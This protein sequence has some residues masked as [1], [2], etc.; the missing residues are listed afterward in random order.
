V[1]AFLLVLFDVNIP[2]GGEKFIGLL[3]A[4]YSAQFSF[5]PLVLG[6][7]FAKTHPSPPWA[8][9]SLIS[10]GLSGIALGVY[11]VFWNDSVGWYPIL[12]CFSLSTAVYLLGEAVKKNV[13]E[14][15]YKFCL[16]N[17]VSLSVLLGAVG[18]SI[19]CPWPMSWPGWFRWEVA[20]FISTVL[21]SFYVY[22][23]KGTLFSPQFMLSNNRK[24]KIGLVVLCIIILSIAALLSVN[25]RLHW[26]NVPD[27]DRPIEVKMGCLWISSILF[28]I[29]VT[30]LSKGGRNDRVAK[31]FRQSLRYSDGPICVSFGLLFFYACWLGEPRIKHEGMESF[32]AGAIAFQMILSNIMWMFA[33]NALVTPAD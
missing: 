16:A 3:I 10:G 30:L 11:S 25:G 21:Y 4:I 20:A 24:H 13:V 33:D 29:A 8:A 2:H 22:I 28:V 15:V 19:F 18:Y 26:V 31:S 6:I 23:F 9:A 14:P 1:G 5:L 27:F 32:F 17:R 12:V 7:L